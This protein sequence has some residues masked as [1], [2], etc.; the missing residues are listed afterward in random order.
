MANEGK[1]EFSHL[2]EE[3]LSEESF[4]EKNL[5]E[6]FWISLVA[7]GEKLE[8]FEPFFSL[9]YKDLVKH[10]QKQE[11]LGMDVYCLE[12][13]VSDYFCEYVKI[14]KMSIIY[15][16]KISGENFLMFGYCQ[17]EMLEELGSSSSKKLAG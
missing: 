10:S 17:K 7:N 9:R 1:N 2:V 4:F 12:K 16:R 11:L 13:K 3:T 14:P 6:G 15:V 5:R 8:S